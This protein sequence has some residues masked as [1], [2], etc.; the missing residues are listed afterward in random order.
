MA[1]ENIS[2][3]TPRY[4]IG[5]TVPGTT[6]VARFFDGSLGDLEPEGDF[7][8]AFQALLDALDAAGFSV[9]GGKRVEEAADF[10]I[11]P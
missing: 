8:D 2:R 1:I 6:R 4:H 7:D 3:D 10:S 5:I 11:T 9:Y